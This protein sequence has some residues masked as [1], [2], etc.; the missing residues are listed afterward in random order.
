MFLIH[1]GQITKPKLELEAR[2]CGGGGPRR[3]LEEE[4]EESNDRILFF[5][6]YSLLFLGL[7]FR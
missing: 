3:I 5:S 4:E 6:S 1:K 7:E 2:C